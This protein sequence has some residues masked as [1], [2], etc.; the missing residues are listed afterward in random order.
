MQLTVNVGPPEEG[1]DVDAVALDVAPLV[2]LVRKT[3]VLVASLD[4]PDVQLPVLDAK[5]EDPPGASTRVV[6]P[7]L[8]ASPLKERLLLGTRPKSL[9]PSLSL[10]TSSSKAK[11]RKLSP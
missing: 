11:P 5:P 9:K 3:D 4:V 10:P 7:R 8:D 2:L 6:V 1:V